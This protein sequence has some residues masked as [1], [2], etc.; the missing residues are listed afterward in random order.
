[1]NQNTESRDSTSF[2]VG[3]RPIA[4]HGVEIEKFENAFIR[5]LDPEYWKLQLD[6]VMAKPKG[7]IS[8]KE[9][10]LLRTSVSQNLEFVMALSLRNSTKRYS[11]V[12]FQKI[13]Y[14]KIHSP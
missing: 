5:N 6:H 9:A 10:T 4:I 1:M 7:S 13:D 14:S 2:V 12:R 11:S 8:A 3:E